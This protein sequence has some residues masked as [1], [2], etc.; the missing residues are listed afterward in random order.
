HHPRADSDLPGRARSAGSAARKRNRC[1]EGGRLGLAR[2][3]EPRR[4]DR[5]ALPR[6]VRPRRAAGVQE[7]R[8]HGRPDREEGE[9]VMNEYRWTDL[10]VV[11]DAQLETAI[12]EAAMKGFAEISGD[13]NPLHL[14]EEFARNRGFRGR[15]T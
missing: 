9:Q 12:T 7:R 13:N 15:V 4:R 3:R 11:L 14:D 5:E 6:Q 1:V 2:A 10:K 8:R